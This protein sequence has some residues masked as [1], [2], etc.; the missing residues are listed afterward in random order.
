VAQVGLIDEKNRGSKISCYCP[1]KEGFGLV[2]AQIKFFI[3]SQKK[4]L[5]SVEEQHYF[6]S[7]P[8]PKIRKRHHSGF[9]HEVF[10][11]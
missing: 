1:F 9:Y 10:I 8:P 7:T 11:V 6:D 5:A 2:K 3:V 4:K